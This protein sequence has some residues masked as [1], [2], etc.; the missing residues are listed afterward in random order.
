MVKRGM[1]SR[2]SGRLLVGESTRVLDENIRRKRQKKQIDALEED[3]FHEDPHSQL[4][5]NRNIPKFDDEQVQG[6]GSVRK[7]SSMDS[8][9]QGEQATPFTSDT[10]AVYL[11]DNCGAPLALTDIKSALIRSFHIR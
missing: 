3:N 6:P 2:H 7:R 1:A 9:E 10:A 11:V 5:W 8:N 4:Q